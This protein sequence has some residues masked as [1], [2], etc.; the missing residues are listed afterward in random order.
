[1]IL[2]LKY[3]WNKY[4]ETFNKIQNKMVLVCS[5]I[6]LILSIWLNFNLPNIA[7]YKW[8][9]YIISE[10]ESCHFW[11]ED[12]VFTGVHHKTSET[13]RLASCACP[14]NPAMSSSDGERCGQLGSPQY[15]IVSCR[16]QQ[17][18]FLDAISI[19][20]IGTKSVSVT[21]IELSSH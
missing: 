17:L 7:E 11:A 16:K 19:S 21:I 4:W 18:S 15:W 3:A 9:I 12:R 10:G 5:T 20:I 6:P 13:F 1:M 2:F 8:G 14:D